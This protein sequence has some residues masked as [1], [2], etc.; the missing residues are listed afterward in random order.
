MF[1]EVRTRG[2]RAEIYNGVA[3]TAGAVNGVR[4]D[5]KLYEIMSY[6]IP[7]YYESIHLFC[8]SYAMGVKLDF[9]GFNF[10]LVLRSWT[11]RLNVYLDR[12]RR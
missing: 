11:G 4:V 7:I 8:S 1:C 10:K 9:F 12:D 2:R 6:R 5:R 3:E